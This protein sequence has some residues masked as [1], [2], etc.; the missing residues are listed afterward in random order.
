[1][2]GLYIYHRK[3]YEDEK[4]RIGREG[5]EGK[6]REG[7]DEWEI[8]YVCASCEREVFVGWVLGYEGGS[9]LSGRHTTAVWSNVVRA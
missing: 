2:V 4:R 3:A 6:R 7:F 1:M 5:G 8:F 9:E